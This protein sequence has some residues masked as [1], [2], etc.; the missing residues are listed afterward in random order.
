MI[1]DHV[2]ATV[3]LLRESQIVPMPQSLAYR[4]YGVERV[5]AE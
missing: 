1:E 5:C 4:L 2:A 3:R